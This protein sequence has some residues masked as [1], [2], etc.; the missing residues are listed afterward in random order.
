MESVPPPLEQRPTRCVAVGDIVIGGRH[1]VAIQSMAAT[2]TRD[3]EATLRQ[4][5]MLHDAGADIVRVAVDSS[6]DVEAV[7]WIASRAHGPL[8]VDLQENYRLVGTVAPHVQKVRYNPGHLHHREKERSAADKVAYIAEQAEKHDCALRI[9]VNRGSVDPAQRARFPAHD[10]I[11]PMVASALEHSEMLDRLGFLRYCVSLKDFDPNVVVE[12]NQRFAA[13]RP[14]VP[15]HLGVTEAG[16][17]PEGIRKTRFALGKLLAQGIG[18][19]LRVSLTVPSED[20]DLEVRAGRQLLLDVQEGRYQP[21]PPYVPQGLDRQFLF[22][23]VYPRHIQ[24]LEW[25]V[26]QYVGELVLVFSHHEEA[27]LL[28]VYSRQR[29]C[30]AVSTRK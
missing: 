4:I 7:A 9:G 18:D 11:G 25:I 14:D 27:S 24:V 23:L 17:P 30:C 15:L 8:S 3:A 16:M 1:P 13:Q 19:T 12:A 28:D 20:K 29:H 6:A 26:A 22:F 21:V 5:Q 2:R 10:R